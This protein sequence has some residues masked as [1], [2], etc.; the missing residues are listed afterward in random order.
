[1]SRAQ[2]TADYSAFTD[3]AAPVGG[4][5]RRVLFRAQYRTEV[6]GIMTD[7][8]GVINAGS[9]SLLFLSSDANEVGRETYRD[10]RR[11]S[12]RL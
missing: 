9:L 12:D 2:T 3:Y 1:M 7:E 8:G 11:Y 10:R 6:A 5:S 4:T